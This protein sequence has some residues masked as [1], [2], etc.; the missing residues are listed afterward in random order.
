MEHS[1]TPTQREWADRVARWQASKLRR[2]EFA[3]REGVAGE[4]LTWWRWKL[5]SLGVVGSEVIPTTSSPPAFVRL[6]TSEPAQNVSET[7][8]L[9]LVLGGD[10]V[11][12]IPVGFDAQTLSRVTALLARGDA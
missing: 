6:E 3:A 8:P 2:D 5:R 9:E 11:L 7:E 4:R 12:R 10:L 1:L